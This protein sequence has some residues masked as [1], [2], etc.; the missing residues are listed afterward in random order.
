MENAFKRLA[1][2]FRS[3]KNCRGMFR[4]I[5]IGGWSS[6]ICES[7]SLRVPESVGLVPVE[8][9]NSGRKFFLLTSSDD[10]H[11][12]SA[13]TVGL[14]DW[15]QESLSIWSEFSVGSELVVDIGAYAGVYSCL[16]GASGAERVLAFEPNP[17]IFDQLRQ[18]VAKNGFEKIVELKPLALANKF[19]RGHTTLMIPP[20]RRLSSGAR[21]TEMTRESWF[22]G[23]EQTAPVE[24]SY[25]DKELLGFGGGS[26][27]IIK[28]DAEGAELRVLEGATDT[29]RRYRPALLLECLDSEAYDQIFS[30]LGDFG[31]RPGRPLDGLGFAELAEGR[32]D[33]AR[34]FLFETD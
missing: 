17:R 29:I 31:Y 13:T 20:G 34:N 16:A 21:L 18:T 25:L 30:F 33:V 2:W 8:I 28:I 24:V 32:G 6:W 27:S 26:I 12:L 19:H 9:E 22:R 1:N 11:Y 23:W 7:R 5:L 15:E 10:D 4:W 14:A 3:K